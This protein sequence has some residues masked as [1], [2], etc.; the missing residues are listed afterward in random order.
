MESNFLKGLDNDTKEY[1]IADGSNP[2]A[3]LLD[4]DLQ[5]KNKSI[6]SDGGSSP[7]YQ[8]TITN[9]K[10]E[11]FN[12]ELNDI[13]RDVFYNQFDLGNIV[14]GTRRIAEKRFGVGKKGVSVKYDANKIVWFAEEIKKYSN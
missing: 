6:Q 14:K 11:T 3:G 13:I 9:D 7:Y 10:G 5:S 12:C 4:L 8:I 2:D 1:G